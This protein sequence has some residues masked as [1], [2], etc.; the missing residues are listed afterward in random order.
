MAEVR[1]KKWWIICALIA[2]TLLAF[3]LARKPMLIAYHQ[4]KM[5]EAWQDADANVEPS[6]SIVQQLFKELFGIEPPAWR[7]NS[8]SRYEH[9]RNRLVLLGY[10]VHR[11]F[12]FEHLYCAS[13]EYRA[14]WKIVTARF[15]SIHTTGNYSETSEPVRIEVWD[16]PEMIPKWEAFVHEHD[17]PDFLERFA[18]ELKAAEQFFERHRIEQERAADETSGS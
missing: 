11:E 17:V 6:V 12:V 13:E 15:S 18:D 10:L 4:K 16:T 9:H 14:L 3:V 8:F 1:A 2:A 7:H 5:K